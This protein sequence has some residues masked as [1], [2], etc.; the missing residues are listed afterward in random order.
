MSYE[1]APATL[2]LAT[3]CCLCGRPLV[4]AESVECGIGPHCRKDKSSDATPDWG[5]VADQLSLWVAEAPMDDARR[6][7]FETA[8]NAIEDA[9]KGNDH[10]MAN[11]LTREIAAVRGSS[12]VGHLVMAI[13]CMGRTRL[14]DALASRLYEIRIRE[15][16]AELL[17]KSPYSDAFRGMTRNLR[18]RWDKEGKF[19]RVGADVRRELYAALKLSYPGQLAF[20]PR[21][22]FLL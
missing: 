11:V 8:M 22:E 4:D 14:A 20:G 1:N 18:A 15:S 19:Y 12:P 3:H 5:A 9:R 6:I 2:L 13:R 10:K 21:G 16:G 7:M 17:V